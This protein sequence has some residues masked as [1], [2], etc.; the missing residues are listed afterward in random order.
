MTEDF[1]PGTRPL[2]R[3]AGLD[4]ERPFVSRDDEIHV[5]W[6][7]ASVLLMR[8]HLH[9]DVEAR[10]E[11]GINDAQV[12]AALRAALPEHFGD[13]A[14]GYIAWALIYY[15]C[16]QKPTLASL[17]PWE[18]LMFEW[19]ER[20]GS[21]PRIA[22]MLRQ[23][24]LDRPLE[25]ATLESVDRWI[26][27]PAA[28]LG[29]ASAIVKALF[30][31][32]LVL[33]DVIHDDAL[34]AVSELFQDLLGSLPVPPAVDGARLRPAAVPSGTRWV[35]EIDR[36]GAPA[37]TIDAAATNASMDVDGVA[38]AVDTLLERLGRPERV[39]RLEPG[40]DRNGELATFVVADGIRFMELV[41]R[42]RLPVLRIP[43]GMTL[44]PPAAPAP[45]A[46]GASA[47]ASSGAAGAA[48]AAGPARAAPPAVGG[49]VAA[50]ARTP[51]PP[52]RAPTPTPA[53]A[54][55]AAG[56]ATLVASSTAPA[57][58]STAASAA[59]SDSHSTPSLL[60]G[61]SMPAGEL[62]LA[63]LRVPA[64]E[65]DGAMRALLAS[66]RR[67]FGAG[68]M[69]QGARWT[70]QSRVEAPAW[71]AASQDPMAAFYGQ[72]VLMLRKG[73][74]VWA[75]LVR[76]AE[77]LFAQGEADLPA[78]IVYSEDAYFDG[79]PA[80]LRSIGARLAELKLP[81]EV[82]ALSE[83]AAQVRD[84]TARPMNVR[85]PGSITAQDVRLTT[86][87]GVRAHLPAARLG[88]EW[89]PV[90][91]HPDSAIPM[92]VPATYWSQ[93]LRAAWDAGRLRPA[94]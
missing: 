35:V 10:R 85:V 88:A 5:I 94:R 90:L 43:K 12:V 32:R 3:L 25:P 26:N 7:V 23:G 22:L 61:D 55:S 81:A 39:F 66:L 54:R 52:T 45:V 34:H 84:D 51:A 19:Q 27:L 44:Q 76:A 33:R 80:E 4:A 29:S 8:F 31:T 47:A 87:M 68:R 18:R 14:G 62:A 17:H 53:P 15:G 56:A 71:I 82:P 64:M 74:I 1:K 72:Q 63:T 49:P 70:A 91:T 28:A 79:R 30:G 77:A 48:A 92:I 89:F 50:A 93:G 83:I 59:A 9:P 78:L 67:T 6:T 38:A 65:P 40:R 13:E 75:A 60:V 24:G 46:A 37:E 2:L 41:W 73:R 42:L 36:R 21:A 86:C 16:R 57:S 58:A 20:R 11:A 69:L